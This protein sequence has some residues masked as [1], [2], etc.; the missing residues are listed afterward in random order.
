M[1][2][3]YLKQIYGSEEDIGRHV[4]RQVIG[5]AILQKLTF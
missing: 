1:L 2:R 4:R 5:A 3:H